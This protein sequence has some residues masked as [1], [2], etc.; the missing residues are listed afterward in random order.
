MGILSISTVFKSQPRKDDLEV[1][2]FL[3]CLVTSC[4]ISKAIFRLHHHHH[5]TLEDELVRT[6]QT[7]P[8]P[9]WG[10][11]NACRKLRCNVRRLI[12]DC[13]AMPNG[14]ILVHCFFCDTWQC[15]HCA[16]ATGDQKVAKNYRMVAEWKLK[17]A[18]DYNSTNN[19]KTD[20]PVPDFNEWL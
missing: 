7:R 4:L 19:N 10:A 11:L 1:L 13:S 9:H 20:I 5:P 3:S 12:M 2:A 18:T 6:R 17:K 14:W 8:R 16:L 15:L